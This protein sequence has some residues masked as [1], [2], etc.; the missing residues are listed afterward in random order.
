M[1]GDGIAGATVTARRDQQDA[2]TAHSSK[3]GE[4]LLDGLRPGTYNFVIEAK[5]YAT[6]IKY[7]VEVKPGKPRDLGGNL[8]LQADR[9]S[10]VIDSRQRFL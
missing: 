3:N 7:S 9:G 5:G 2:G 1:N 6:G 10:Q 4:F 8:L